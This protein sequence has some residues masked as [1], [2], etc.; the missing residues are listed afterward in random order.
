MDAHLIDSR[1]F[2]HQW[3][4]H[5]ALA[6][7]SEEARVERWIEILIALA[8]AQAECGIIPK[9]SAAE[10]S[11]L[12]EI[13]LSIEDIAERTRQTSHSTLGL[14]QVL[15][16]HLTGD[17]S[18]HVYYGATVQDISDTAQALELRSVAGIIWRDLWETEGILVK[19]ASRHR[20]TPMV[21]RTHGQPGAPIT[22][23]FKV[24]SWADELSRHLGRLRSGCD[25]WLVGQLAGAVGSLAFFQ[26]RGLALREVFCARLGLDQPAISWTS[27]RDRLADFANFAAMAASSAARIANEVYALQRREI[28]ELAE[29]ANVNTVGSITMPHKRNPESSE[30][31]VALAR[32]ARAEAA[33]LTETMVQEHERDARGWK[34]EWA[35]FPTL[36]HYV[37]ACLS[38]TRTLVEGLEVDE[39]AM[40]RNLGYGSGSEQT[41]SLMSIRLGK[42]R[43]QAL[44][45]DAFREARETGKPVAE[46]LRPLATPEESNALDMV[47]L[48]T[49]PE[50]VDRVVALALARRAA[51]SPDWLE[52]SDR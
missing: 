25:I 5:E 30:Q 41:L 17:A 8:E 9:Q 34:I 45:Q 42:H 28:G 22:F 36:C 23:G 38:M 14:I 32:M 52:H 40:R 44:L 48:G 6:I 31:I 4:T 47:D 29:K 51:E 27:S 2:G 46:V 20:D 24:A 26:E 43:A 19:M 13:R 35:A 33:L 39:Q 37:L 3:T 11:R 18:E 50:M 7:F 15:R 16:T 49:A 1:V 12:R 10:I 21:G